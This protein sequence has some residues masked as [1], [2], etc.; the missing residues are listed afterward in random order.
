MGSNHLTQHDQCFQHFQ[1]V[2]MVPNDIVPIFN[3]MS[4]DLGCPIIQGRVKRSIF[5]QVIVQSQKKFAS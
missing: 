1:T 2:V 3:G 4:K 5:F